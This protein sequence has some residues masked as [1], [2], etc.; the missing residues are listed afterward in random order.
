MTFFARTTEQGSRSYVS[1]ITR[2]ADSQG[3]LW[4]DDKYYSDSELGEMIGT[5]EGEKL[6]DETWKD[7]VEVMR[8]A[9]PGVRSI[10]ESE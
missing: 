2:G 8:K 1:A 10:L 5:S 4:K 3:Q 7:L 6:G 9:D